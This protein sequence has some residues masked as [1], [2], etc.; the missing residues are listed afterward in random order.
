MKRIAVIITAMLLLAG[1]ALALGIVTG[2]FS[3]KDAATVAANDPAFYNALGYK[4]AQDGNAVDAQAAFARA[5]ELDQDYENARSNLATIA[6]NNGDYAS[7]I[8]QLRWLVENNPA[9]GNYHFDLAQNLAS[10]ARYKTADPGELK[11][12][13]SEF[14]VAASFGVENA[15]SNAAVVRNVVAEFS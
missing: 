13:A 9:N 2:P 7:A 10:D 12:A 6:F 5:V 4:L 1:G 11:E 3:D 8:E 15:A 14:D